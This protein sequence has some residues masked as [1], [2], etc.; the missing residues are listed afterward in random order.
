MKTEEDIALSI[1]DIE[2]EDVTALDF[3]KPTTPDV[4]D[5]VDDSANPGQK[6]FDD[7]SEDDQDSADDQDDKDADD[8]KDDKDDQNDQEEESLLTKIASQMGLEFNEEE[9]QGIEETEEGIVRFT[10]VA[11]GKLATMK[12]Q[13]FM[14][15]HPLTQAI[16]EH[17]ATGGDP[18]EFIQ[19][20]YASPDYSSV[21]FNDEDTDQHKYLVTES[22]K[23]KGFSE[24]RIKRTL[25]SMEDSGSL[26]AE[27]QDSLKDLQ[28]AQQAER[29][30]LKDEAKQREQ[31]QALQ[32][33]QTWKEVNAKI[34]SGKIASFE[35]PKTKQAEFLKFI[36]PDPKTGISPR[37]QVTQQMDIEK[38][39]AMDYILFNG[40]EGL[41][42]ILSK[43]T[44]TKQARTIRDILKSSKERGGN[45]TPPPS[46]PTSV[47]NLEFRIG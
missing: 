21:E 47:D 35:I 34:T 24:E 38:A 2:F 40:F 1:D 42:N 23:S 11:A 16:Y 29:Q 45:V 4:S 17:E 9:L 10:D 8:D 15:S 46:K 13:Q 22:L 32:A 41:E 5:D 39:L 19:A 27:A 28:T 14:E 6:S 7:D 43:K 30:R 37:D 12:L 36:T 26:S 44:A 33:Q 31:Q 20:Y 18:Q 3:S 25:Q